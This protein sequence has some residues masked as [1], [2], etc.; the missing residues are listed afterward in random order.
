MSAKMSAIISG[1]TVE[2][3]EAIGIFAESIGI[4]FQI[5]DDIL[6]IQDATALSQNK[7]GVGEDIHEGKRTIMVIHSFNT[8]S[9]SDVKRLKEIL[10][11]KTNNVE[12]IHEAIAILKKNK[13]IEFAQTKM[14]DLITEAWNDLIQVLPAS[15]AQAKL[16]ALVDYLIEREL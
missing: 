12:L 14:R 15:T 16:K 6:N 13:S 10:A 11:M 3:V 4:A 1:A 7:G 9:E 8:G 2:Q 5:Q